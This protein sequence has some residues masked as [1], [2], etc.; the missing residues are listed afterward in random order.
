M[1]QMILLKDKGK[2]DY[3]KIWKYF[4]KVSGDFFYVYTCGFSFFF[5]NIIF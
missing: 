1:I 4:L 2:V 3:M 5:K